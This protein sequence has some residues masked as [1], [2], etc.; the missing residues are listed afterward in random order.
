MND[1]P[2]QNYRGNRFRGNTRRYNRHDDRGMKDAITIIEIEMGQ[3]KG[4]S[5]E[6]TI[7]TEIEVQATVDQGQGLEPVQIGIG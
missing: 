3:E 6:I 5:Q 2:R 1:G 4:I 7:T